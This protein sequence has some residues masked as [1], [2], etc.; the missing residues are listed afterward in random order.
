MRVRHLTICFLSALFMLLSMNHDVFG[1][2]WEWPEVRSYTSSDGTFRFH[3]IPPELGVR[4]NPSNSGLSY[5]E[6]RKLF[7]CVGRLEK[8]T[9]NLTYHTVWERSLVNDVA[10]AGGAKVTNNG[11]YVVT[12]DDWSHVGYGPN[13]VVIYGPEGGLV[14]RLSL[15]DFLSEE[16]IAS[17]LHTTSSIWW[18]HDHYLS[19]SEEELILQVPE[20]GTNFEKKRTQIK[21]W[22]IRVEL[23]TGKILGRKSPKES[24]SKKQGDLQVAPLDH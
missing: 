5:E 6:K 4:H 11:K 20:P 14:K 16:H 23:A 2:S 18:C 24:A 19:K 22:E 9:S 7:P 17:L 3:V 8:R 10:P 21:V 12:F 15:E 13:T 1:D